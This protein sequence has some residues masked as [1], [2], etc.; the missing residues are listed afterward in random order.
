VEP[1]NQ[2][3]GP[4]VLKIKVPVLIV[5]LIF[6]VQKPNPVQGNLDW[7]WRLIAY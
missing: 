3:W 2:V 5:V 4:V 6:Q 7:D 1:G